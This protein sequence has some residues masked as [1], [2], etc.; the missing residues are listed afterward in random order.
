LEEKFFVNLELALHA[1]LILL[2]FLMLHAILLLWIVSTISIIRSQSKPEII[3]QTY[4]NYI[5]T[6]QRYKSEDDCLHGVPAEI[7]SQN[8]EQPTACVK[9]RHTEFSTFR[10]SYISY[11]EFQ[12]DSFDYVDAPET[13]YANFTDGTR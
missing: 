1:F 13:I 10:D 11:D 2:M 7:P 9:P 12:R 5:T 3:N 6:I 4:A 8:R